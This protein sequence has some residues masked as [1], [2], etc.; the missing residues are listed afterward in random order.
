MKMKKSLRK[1][2]VLPYEKIIDAVNGF[3][4]SEKSEDELRELMRRTPH[5]NTAYVYSLIKE[6]VLRLKKLRLF[7]SQLAAAYAMERGKIAELPTGEGKSLSAVVAA[8]SESLKGRQVHILVFNDYLAERDFFEH[9]DIYDFCGVLASCIL[10]DSSANERK[11]AYR[12]EVLYITAKEAGFDYLRNFAAMEPEALLEHRFD[13]AIVDEADSLLIDESKIPLVL[14][15]AVNTVP[16]QAVQAQ[17]IIKEL[18]PEHIGL[19]KEE[20]QIWFTEEGVS[21]IEKRAEIA[22]LYDDKNAI[23]LSLL[24]IMLEA[25][26]FYKKDRDY[27]IKENRVYIVEESTGRTVTDRKFPDYL[28]RAIEL[29]EDVSPESQTMILNTM[30]LQFFFLKYASLC[31]MTGTA[32]TSEKEF[33]TMY[34]LQVEVIPP[35]TVCRRIDH[36]DVVC[37]TDK[38]LQE[39]LLDKLLCIHEKGQPVLLGTQS[40]GE[41]EKYAELIR[42]Q[43]LECFVLNARQDAKEAELIA[44]AGEPYRITVS[45]NMA[46]RGVDIKL[47]NGD[48]ADG[49]FVRKA[50]GLF[51]LSTGINRSQRIDAQLRGRAGRQGDPGESQLFVS[52]QQDFVKEFFQGKTPRCNGK[53]IRKVQQFMEGRDA[54][55]RYI[56]EK[57]SVI[58]EKQRQIISNYRENVLRNMEELSLLQEKEPVLYRSCLESAGKGGLQRAQQQLMLYYLNQ[59]WADYLVTMENARNGIHLSVIG[60][61]EPIHVYQRFAVKAFAEMETDILEDVLWSLRQFKI[62]ES[63]VDLKKEG[64]ELPSSTWTYMI[65]E[66]KGQFVRLPH[67]MGAISNRMKGV[68]RRANK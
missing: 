66:S 50:G 48:E 4:W 34:G 44:K 31:G 56:L 43:G 33:K 61:E 25:E 12:S 7:D 2:P 59:H 60:R 58:L 21:Y 63:G 42:E 1:G 22:N 15:G 17:A 65:D 36:E 41:S 54:Q 35:H 8:I 37:P 38:A 28:Q 6:V 29:K 13:L 3:D 52:L 39:S 5:L 62:T 16:C 9:R 49:A 27:I 24:H 19:N 51:V 67:L 45:T 23:L 30:P 40:V 55:A 32:K 57:Y 18:H 26:W 11:K 46:G 64:L 68:W 53:T 10:Q 20:R 14:A 47:G